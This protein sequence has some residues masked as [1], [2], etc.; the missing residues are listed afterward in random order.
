VERFEDQPLGPA[1]HIA[2]FS[3]TKVGNFV[4]TT[5][6]LRG[7]KEKYPQATLDFFGSDVTRD[8]EDACPYIDFRFSLYGRDD[9]FLESLSRAVTERRV[10]AGEYDLAVNCDE[11]AELNVVAVTLVRPRYIAG[12]ALAP[13]LR[14]RLPAGTRPEHRMLLDQDWNSPSFLERYGDVLDSNYIAEILCRIAY[15]ETD[16]FRLEVGSAP[17]SFD[18]PDVLLH[19]TTTRSA[20]MWP[21]G[22]WLE[23]I[24]WLAGRDLTVGLI[25]SAP[26][27][28]RALY[29]AGDTEDA[30]L[31][32]T[33]LVDLRGR[34]P[35]LELAGALAR[36]RAL[37]TVDAGPLHVAAAVGCPT[38][39]VFGADAHGVGASPLHLWAPRRPF[40]RVTASTETCS[41]CS[42]RRFK[43]DACLVEGHP[44]MVGVSV[45]QV[46]ALLDDI[47]VD[48]HPRPANGSKPK[49][50]IDE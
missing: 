39:A 10:V 6:L 12:G 17:P 29:N 43:N 41:V 35:L 49:E 11:F 15:V 21:I 48:I 23:V 37:V 25:G 20:K 42:E 1:P 32:R 28:Q 8:F 44:C 22:H 19:V 13:D 38:V 45:A 26:A 30:L 31:E 14:G 2:V 50:V 24:R 9:G 40:V 18:V 33:E 46:R 47:L 34:T 16:Y 5:P 3:S 4:V 27:A 7:L 36:T